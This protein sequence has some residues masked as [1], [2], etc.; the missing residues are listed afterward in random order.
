[1]FTFLSRFRRQTAVLTALALVA[2]VLVTVPVSA[3]DDDPKADYEATF[4]AC[5]GGAAEDAGFTDVPSGHENAGDINCIGYY[6]ITRGTSAS[7]YSPLMSVTREHMALFLTR[8]AGLVGIE[9]VS[10]PD[11][12]GFTDIGDLSDESQ[13]AIN[14]LA[15]LGVT[16]GT[17]ATTYSPADPVQRGHMALFIS[18]LMDQMDPFANPDAGDDDDPFAYLPKEVEDTDDEPVGSPFTDLGSVTKSTYDAITNLWELGVASGMGPTSYNPSASITRA[19]MAGFMAGVLDHSNARP[20]GVT[21]QVNKITDFGDVTATRAIS[22]R[23]D[24]FAPVGDVSVKVFNATDSGGFDDDTG[25]CLANTGDPCDW[26]DN[27]EITN[28]N[29][30]NFDTIDV[31][32]T[33]ADGTGT[34]NTE[35]SETWYAWMGDEDN[36]EFVKG[37][38]GEAS[39]TLTA[40][41]NA[42]GIRVTADIAANATTNQVDVNKD[43]T[44]VIIAQL[45]DITTVGATPAAIADAGAVAKEGVELTIGW[46]QTQGG[47]ETPVFP[48]PDAMKTDA[49]GKV[50]FTIEGPPA[51]GEG[52]PEVNRDD[53]VTFTGD[54]DGDTDLTADPVVPE[55]ETNNIVVQ[56]RSANA[57]VN[58]GTAKTDASYVIIDDDEVRIMVTVSYYDQYG[59]PAGSGNRLTITINNTDDTDTETGQASSGNN[60]A[61]VR[62]NG[63][64]RFSANLKADAGDTFEITVSELSTANTDGTFTALNPAVDADDLNVANGD[65]VLAVRLAHKNDDGVSANRAATGNQVIV[66][67]DNDRFIIDSGAADSATD[68]AG[69]LY[70]YDSGD[71]LIVNDVEVEMDKFEEAIAM[72]GNTVTVVLYNPDPDGLSIFTVK[73]T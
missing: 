31:A 22:V 51:P 69:V 50:T 41:A 73:P 52:D 21:M 49:D 11:D 63:I 13:T 19:A 53:Q 32:T 17:S 62:S 5:V 12:A 26:G 2:S 25:K 64:A 57:G 28:D 15:D 1:M 24:S 56:W 38:S 14:Q 29:G 45:I 44:V 60:M 55:V 40:K 10:D 48:P 34:G 42:L 18:R 35:A 37:S 61:R 16:Q 67:A 8:L 27:E 70:S 59:N 39:V 66:D 20:E 23:D 68:R 9:V 46:T 4:S 71:R 43:K 58:K 6:G 3:A 65:A 33:G 72:N 30:N 54:V 47:T 7:T 36:D